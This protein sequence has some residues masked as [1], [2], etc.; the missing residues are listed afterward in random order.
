[1]SPDALRV[2]FRCDGYHLQRRT[3]NMVWE[4]LLVCSELEDAE[5]ALLAEVTP[6]ADLD[7]Y[8]SMT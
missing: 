3:D 7:P 4:D 6:T 1:M 8:G 5:R 2:V